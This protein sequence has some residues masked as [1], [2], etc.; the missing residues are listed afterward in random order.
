[1]AAQDSFREFN[2]ALSEQDRE[3][4]RD[5][6]ASRRDEL[7]AARSEDARTRLVDQYVRQVHDMLHRKQ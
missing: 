5:F 3:K 7:L 4:L 1:M 2:A 6:I